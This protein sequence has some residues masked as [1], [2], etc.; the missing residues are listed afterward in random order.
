MGARIG[1]RVGLKVEAE[2]GGFG[3][4][5]GLGGFIGLRGF[6]LPVGS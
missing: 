4:A 6:G 1:A 5:I 2:A 3:F